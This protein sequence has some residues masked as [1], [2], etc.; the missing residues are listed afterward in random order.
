[1]RTWSVEREGEDGAFI[2]ECG[3]DDIAPWGGTMQYTTEFRMKLGVDFLEAMEVGI[4]MGCIV[5]DVK[6]IEDGG[7]ELPNL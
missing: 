6:A 4:Q 2:R 5:I 3:G 7:S 1:M